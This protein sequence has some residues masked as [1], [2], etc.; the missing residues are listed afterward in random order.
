T[1]GRFQY[2]PSKNAFIAVNRTNQNVYIYKLTAG[3][4]APPPAD[5]TPPTVSLTAPAA[6]ATVSGTVTLTAT[7]TDNVG[8]TSVQFTV[9]GVNAGAADTTAPYSVAWNTTTVTNG[10]HTLAAVARDAAGNTRT[11]TAVTVTVSN[12]T[13]D[14]TPPTVA[15]TAPAAGSTVSGTVTLTATA[16][17]NVG[18]ASVQ[19]TVDGVNAGAADTTAPYSVA[20]DTTTA[21][22]GTHTLAAIARDAA[23]NTRTATA[24]TVTVS[25]S[26]ADTTRPKVSITAPTAGSTV[27][28]IVTVTA[29][30]T[31]NVGV[32]SV[33]FRVDGKNVGTLDTA[34]PYTYEWDTRT[35]VNGTH[36]LAAVARDA[37]GNT[38]TSK[39]V[40]VTVSNTTADTT[41]PTVS[42]TAPAAGAT[43]SGTVT[44]TAT[45]T[46]NVGVASVQFTVDGV[47]VAADTT[48]PYS[49]VWDTT[50]VANGT[51]T[52][53]ATARDAA[54]NSRTATAVT[55]T[56]SNVASG[57]S[58]RVTGTDAWCDIVNVARPGDEI[59]FAPGSYTQPCWI[60][61][62]GT[63][64]GWITLRSESEFDGQRATFAYAGSTANV[65]E[66]LSSAAYLTL[67]GFAFGPTQDAVDAIR[68]R[69]GHDL[70]IERNV[71]TA[72]GGVS[73]AANDASTERLTLR[74]NV[75][76]DLPT[77]AI[78]LG[79]HDGVACAATQLL[80]ERNLIDGVTPTDGSVGYGV[81]I[82]LNS[83]GTVRDNTIYRPNGPG[84]MVYGSDRGDPAS[85]VEGNYV[86][87]SR[88][89]G[90]IVVGGGPAIV[91]N[92]VLVGNAYGGVSAQ[93]YGSRGLQQNV[94]IVHNTILGN[95]DSGINVQAWNSGAGNVI[96]YNA[97]LPL[98][99]TAALRPS[100]P[101]GTVIG[102]VT[103]AIAEV[104]F[105]NGTTPPYDLWPQIGGPLVDAAG[106]GTEPW[107]PL[108]D[109][110][111]V[112][113]TGAADVGAFERTSSGN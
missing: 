99:G 105:V 12:A 44:V 83:W 103:C 43:V 61:A 14:T 26:T 55:V 111:G 3:A 30:A 16:T 80:V 97:I 4:P 49:V 67:R 88:T 108:D 32:A 10:T 101:I 2:I 78:Y 9:D 36:R 53:A 112:P 11:A 100:A 59:V 66:I 20:W 74:D 64:S 58:R 45:A 85:I 38:R 56:V 63:A 60:G 1:Y 41:P 95:A 90:G 52:L 77:T 93:N 13:A 107:R 51:H 76:R 31:D 86:E 37:A 18:V 8:V 91:R 47:N 84:I 23:G 69:G 29:T 25:N 65:L 92:N 73:V 113:R 62:Q 87:G 19:F 22:N 70:V 15:L 35:V 57:T 106:S 21:A 48:A 7:A 82:K 27:S 24:V 54:G 34:A 40:T 102:N 50:T 104:C 71:F 33:R 94:W 96:A 89:E 109:F 6:G 39:A 81:Q 28:G 72:I 68:I 75:F 46:D 79:C 110:M 98:A 42:V 5:T 17:D